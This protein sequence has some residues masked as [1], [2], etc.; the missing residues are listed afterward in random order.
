[1]ISPGRGGAVIR[2]RASRSTLRWSSAISGR[3]NE[4][5]ILNPAG[6]RALGGRICFETSGL[7]VIKTVGIPRISIS[8]WTA[9]TVR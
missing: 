5:P 9:T 3:P 8:R 2:D 1:M 7:T 4:F 6:Y